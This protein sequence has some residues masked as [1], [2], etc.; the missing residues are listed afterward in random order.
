MTC[1]DMIMCIIYEKSKT[2]DT[3]EVYINEVER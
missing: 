2:N 1:Q 3:L